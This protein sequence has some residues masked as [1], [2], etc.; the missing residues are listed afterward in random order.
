MI[1]VKAVAIARRDQDSVRSPTFAVRP[2]AAG[3]MPRQLPCPACQVGGIAHHVELL[4][5]D[6]TAGFLVVDYKIRSTIRAIVSTEFWLIG[7]ADA[8][9]GKI[10]AMMSSLFE[11]TRSPLRDRWIRPSS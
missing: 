8:K 3:I 9:I 1:R 10:F 4:D 2:N 7:V 5:H 6:E 11:R